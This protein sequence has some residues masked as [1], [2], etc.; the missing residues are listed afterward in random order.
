ML[1]WATKNSG[2]LAW[3]ALELSFSPVMTDCYLQDCAHCCC[4][5]STFFYRF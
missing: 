2:K 3:L 4:H 5:S 1:T